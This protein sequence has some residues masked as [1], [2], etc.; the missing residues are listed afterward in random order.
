MGWSRKRAGQ[1]GQ[2]THQG[3]YRDVHEHRHSAGTF[4]TER[5]AKRAADRAEDDLA[6]GRIGDPRQGRQT[7]GTYVEDEWFPNHMLEVSS[8]ETY[9][10]RLRLY[11]LPELST[12][13]MAEITSNDLR[14]WI[15][16]LQG[17]DFNASPAT[18]EKCKTIVDA[19]FTTAFHDKIIPLHPG[20][21]VKTPPVP[22]RPRRIVTP[23][24]YELVHDALPD[25]GMRMLV[26]TDIES[27]LRW[28][29][30]T[31][32]RRSDL[33]VTTRLLTVSRAVVE[34][35]SKD[36]PDDQRFIVK[37][38]PKDREWRSF[39]LS[40]QLV[41]K[42]VNHIEVCKLGQDDLLFPMPTLTNARRTRP[43]TLP[44]PETLGRTEPNRKG[45]SYWHGTPTA[46][47]AGECRCQYCKK[48]C[49]RLPCQQTIGWE[50]QP[51]PA[52]LRGDGRP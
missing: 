3:L 30:L 13:R 47:G 8:R 34:L 18:I 37:N 35:T 52:R 39:K 38:Y 51:P 11:I 27:G 19:I 43:E 45:R 29:E 7:L 26:E 15:V 25:E 48:C 14:E 2:I 24:Q 42:I 9:R 22:K 4:A 6:A 20:R 12:M 46:Y 32:L 40:V 44:T 28:G 31:E 5:A 21:G 41:A 16:K 33:D 17:S 10:N 49:R 50:R 36:R 1:H 23:E